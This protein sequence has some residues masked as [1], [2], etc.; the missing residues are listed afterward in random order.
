M[1]QA[2]KPLA[3]P[4]KVAAFINEGAPKPGT[5]NPMIST[6][7][8]ISASGAPKPVTPFEPS[9]KAKKE[10]AGELTPL[11]SVNV[12]LPADLSKLLLK[13]SSERKLRKSHPYTQQNIIAEALQNWLHKNGYMPEKG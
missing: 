8:L 1:L 11:V 12:R 3:I 6:P 5:P 13:A 7:A 2:V 10:L 9:R 4:P